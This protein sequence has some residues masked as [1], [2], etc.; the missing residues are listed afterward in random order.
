MSMFDSLNSDSAVARALRVALAVVLA[1]SLCLP[2]SVS[3]AAMADDAQSVEET[4]SRDDSANGA[5]DRVENGPVPATPEQG[6][7]PEASEPPIS[8][9]ETIDI[10]SPWQ[11]G[12]ARIDS[13]G[14]YVLTADVQ[15]ESPLELALPVGASAVVDLA[16]FS[17][18]VAGDASCAVDLSDN[19]GTVTFIDSTYD[20]DEKKSEKPLASSITLKAEGS[21]HNA[22]LAAVSF[23]RSGDTFD[24][25]PHVSFS[26]IRLAV[27]LGVQEQDGPT[28]SVSAVRTG[29]AE[30]DD[31]QWNDRS[32]AEIAL[33]EKLRAMEARSESIAGYDSHA[34]VASTAV[35][36]VASG[37][38]DVAIGTQRDALRVGG[39]QFVPLQTEWVD[40]VVT[41]TIESRP[42][43][44][45]LSALLADE[46]FHRDVQALSPCDLSK[47]GS[48]IYES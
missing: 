19:A 36:R 28:I 26:H 21:A 34:P 10:T 29:L 40:L 11:A 8:G 13:A 17:V 39:V 46:K 15:A 9:N 27:E 43:I 4:V 3:F 48:I 41:K 25:T 44:R 22:P 30:E 6:E 45:R 24:A 38:A 1:V 18:M 33:D 35:K 20:A 7:V 37:L 14:S 2:S 16:G 47:M 31:E 32:T 42:Y 23:V 12:E 5:T